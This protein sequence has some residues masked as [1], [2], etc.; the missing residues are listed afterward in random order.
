MV[1]RIE[2]EQPPFEI[3]R[4]IDRRRPGRVEYQNPDL[5]DLLRDE[6]HADTVPDQSIGNLAD[7]ATG[8]EEDAL[9]AARGVG[10]GMLV[11]AC[12][13]TIAGFG[14]WLLF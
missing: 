4:L 7:V 6:A 12:I 8:I 9:A 13:W 2:N 10:T 14:L 11:G 3:V 5:V 1:D